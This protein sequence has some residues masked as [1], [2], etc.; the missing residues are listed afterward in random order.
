[1]IERALSFQSPADDRSKIWIW[2]ESSGLKSDRL[3]PA[4][5]RHLRKP[6][7][8]NSG[9]SSERGNERTNFGPQETHAGAIAS[10]MGARGA[11]VIEGRAL[12]G[13]MT[14]EWSR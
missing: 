6:R 12:E 13:G 7:E 9:E 3:P 10:R 2:S 14:S 11:G 8:I 5:K 1:M 4:T